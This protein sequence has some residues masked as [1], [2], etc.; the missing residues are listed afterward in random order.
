MLWA[1]QVL[2][3]SFPQHSPNQ[4]EFGHAL[5]L[6]V[7]TFKKAANQGA[8]AF[9]RPAY[10]RRWCYASVRKRALFLWNLQRL[11]CVA[12]IGTRALTALELGAE[13]ETERTEFCDYCPGPAL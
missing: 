11:L 4:L 12:T 10:A 2:I 3:T 5:W 13:S 1:Q 6:I 8:V 9:I 7:I